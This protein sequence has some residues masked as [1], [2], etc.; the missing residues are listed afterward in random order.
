[1][2]REESIGGLPQMQES[3]EARSGSV[4]PSGSASTLME[5]AESASAEDDPRRKLKQL[6]S[7]S[8]RRPGVQRKPVVGRKI[9]SRRRVGIR[10]EARRD[11]ATGRNAGNQV[12]IAAVIRTEIRQDSWSASPMRSRCAS[13]GRRRSVDGSPSTGLRRKAEAPGSAARQVQV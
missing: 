5:S 2:E 10:S 3:P 4:S 9:D 6:R 7:L 11:D 13:V 8:S 12:R 1:V